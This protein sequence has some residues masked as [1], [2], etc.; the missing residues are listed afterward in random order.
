MINHE[1]FHM[2]A[3]IPHALNEA[4]W[5]IFCFTYLSTQQTAERYPQVHSP[6]ILNITADLAE[7]RLTVEAFA[8]MVLI[9]SWCHFLV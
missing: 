9:I 5:E 2:D 4:G 3:D 7:T 6:V 1:A 8:V